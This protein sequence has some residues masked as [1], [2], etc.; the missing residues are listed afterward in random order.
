MTTP[1]KH[2]HRIVCVGDSLTFGDSGLGHRN[3]RPWPEQIGVILGVE[4][5]NC[6]RNAAGTIE[7]PDAP[8]YQRALAAMPEADL[9][10]L[11]LG[12][13]DVIHDQATNSEE[14]PDVFNRLQAIAS[15]LLDAVRPSGRDI[16]VA[17][18]KVPLTCLDEPIMS[19]FGYEGL[20]RFN[21]L[22]EQLNALYRSKASAL[23]W[24]LVDYTTVFNGHRELHGDSIHP[25]QA[26]VDAIAATLAPQ[27]KALLPKD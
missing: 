16:P 23:G 1:T 15:S 17:L 20:K 12:I 4:A 18:L 9:L 22:I 26:G 8:A 6:G 24:H 19:R 10:V 11:G 3:E 25:N 13:N 5:V 21:P 7:Y 27:F 2:L 14:L